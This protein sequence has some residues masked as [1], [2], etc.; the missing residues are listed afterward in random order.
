V[1][2]GGGAMTVFMTENIKIVFVDLGYNVLPS[3]LI[4]SHET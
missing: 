2:C 3:A 1:G 4:N